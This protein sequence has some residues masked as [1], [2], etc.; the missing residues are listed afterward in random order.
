MLQADL[1]SRTI[2]VFTEDNELNITVTKI[3]Q[4]PHDRTY[5]LMMR[6]LKDERGNLTFQWCL[7]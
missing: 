6:W 2:A 3:V 1:E 7:E 4:S 5:Q